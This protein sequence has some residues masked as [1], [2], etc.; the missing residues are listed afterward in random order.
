MSEGNHRNSNQFGHF[1]MC[2]INARIGMTSEVMTKNGDLR[3]FLFSL[4]LCSLA[5]INS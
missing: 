1:L 4:N 5:F 3:I 2:L